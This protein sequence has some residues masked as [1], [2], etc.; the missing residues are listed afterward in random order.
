[1]QQ[2][3]NFGALEDFHLR[4]RPGHHPSERLYLGRL[5]VMPASNFKSFQDQGKP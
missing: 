4:R 1:M 3:A 2:K 5:E